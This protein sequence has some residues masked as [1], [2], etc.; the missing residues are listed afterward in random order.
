MWLISA[1]WRNLGTKDR[2]TFS[3]FTKF[4][5][6]KRFCMFCGL[7]SKM[8]TCVRSGPGQYVC[9]KRHLSAIPS[10]KY[11]PYVLNHADSGLHDCVSNSSRSIKLQLQFSATLI[12]P[13]A[14]TLWSLYAPFRLFPLLCESNDKGGQLPFISEGK[15][16]RLGTDSVLLANSR[17]IT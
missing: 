14:A 5:L 10:G 6:T 1:K 17:R 9:I 7:S 11:F 15:D 12:T 13:C 8:A 3:I 4:V 16:G 2:S